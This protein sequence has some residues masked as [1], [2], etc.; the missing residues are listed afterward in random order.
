MVLCVCI[1]L[2]PSV[3]PSTGHL[4]RALE[5]INQGNLTAAEGEARLAINEPATRAAAWAT[6]GTIRLQQAKYDEGERLLRRALSLDPRLVGARVSLGGLYLMRGKTDSARQQFHR[7]LRLDPANHNARLDLAELETQAGN[8]RA[9]LDAARPIRA[10][11]RG[12]PEGLLL[13]AMDYAGL[14]EKDALAALVSDWQALPQAREDSAAGFA[15]LLLRTGLTREAVAVLEKAKTSAPNSERLN[16]MLA[17]C[18]FAAGE[19]AKA[20]ASY[21]QALGQKPGC[22]PCLEGAARVAEREGNSEKALAYLIKARHQE[23]NNPEVLFEFGKVCLERDL[24]E[25]AL[26][27]LKKAVELRP[28]DDSY[29]YVLA[30]AHVARKQYAEARALLERLLQKHPNNAVFNYALGTVL[31]LDFHYDAAERYLKRS[32][33]LR[34]DQVAAYYYLGLTEEKRGHDE[35]AMQVYRALL[36]RQPEHAPTYEALGALLVKQKRYAQA[37]ALLEKA[38]TLD[39]T[40]IKAHYQLAVLLGRMG[41][42]DESNREIE[43]ARKLESE[44]ASKPRLHL[45]LPGE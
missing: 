35:A 20:S 43:I 27:N 30:S 34:P 3:Y 38:V 15:S 39:P 25:D 2:C 6:L 8:Y 31:Y 14:G 16:L 44:R 42:S 17:D 19:L 36:Q 23:P 22:V 37:Q 28:G 29:V 32:I 40:L 10:D 33:E 21:E 4:Q 7:A 13:L 11:L 26:S 41:K 1:S 12:S 45:L 9:S 5:F 24:V 18:Y